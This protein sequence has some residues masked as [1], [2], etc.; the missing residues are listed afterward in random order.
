MNLFFWKRITIK[1]GDV[2]TIEDLGRDEQVKVTAIIDGCIY[3]RYI[4]TG[5]EWVVTAPDFKQSIIDVS[6]IRSEIRL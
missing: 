1:V 3:Y 2:L 6:K 5:M 4:R